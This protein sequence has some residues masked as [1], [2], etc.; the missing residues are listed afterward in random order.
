MLSALRA[1]RDVLRF[2]QRDETSGPGTTSRSAALRQRRRQV[3]ALQTV[4]ADLGGP[5]S[6]R[7]GS[8]RSWPCVSSAGP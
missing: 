3:K 1:G 8:S 5:C 4:I 2:G 6:A 7:A